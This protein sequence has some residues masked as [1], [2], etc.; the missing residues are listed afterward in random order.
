M[1]KKKLFPAM[2]IFYVLLL[3]LLIG[4]IIRKFTFT[5]KQ[6][7]SPAV[8]LSLE[9][10]EKQEKNLVD[11]IYEWMELNSDGSKS[12]IADGMPTVNYT[13]PTNE[14]QSGILDKM[15]EPKKW[16]QKCVDWTL[17]IYF[18]EVETYFSSIIPQLDSYQ[19]QVTT[20]AS[21]SDNETKTNSKD[22]ETTRER[23][24]IQSEAGT[25]YLNIP[26]EEMIPSKTIDPIPELNVAPN[27]EVL[28]KDNRITDSSPVKI[29][30]RKPRILIYH[31]HTSES[32]FD[33]KNHMD[34]TWH[35]IL[36]HLGKIVDVGE[37]LS[38]RL[39]E[40]GIEVYHDKSSYD[41]K[42][43][44]LAYVNSREG[45]SKKLNETWFD[46]IIDIHRD[47]TDLP[48]EN[49]LVNINGKPAAKVL[50][51]L[52]KGK[53]I[54][55]EGHNWETNYL[56]C[57]ALAKKTDAKYP[58]LLRRIVIKDFKRYNQDLHPQAIL[59]EIG[60]QKNTTAEAIYSA[61]L[62]AEVIAELFSEQP[63]FLLD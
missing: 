31:T 2:F 62:L 50:Y 49:Y 33:D 61:Q 20:V 22:I 24:V 7:V 51:L 41:G 48:R 58:D 59:F 14:P 40:L 13:K 32:Y 46:M 9:V 25:I 53:V 11:Q 43:F 26:K 29:N 57:S 19:K 6:I 42:K 47:G 1:L 5:P 35:A 55:D 39:Q 45:V 16:M 15:I 18:G 37:A 17:D 63:V 23:R 27:E 38:N 54:S 3:S 52:T 4:L 60:Y 12:I 10:S 8:S 36:P 44:H 28:I 34:E 56:I 30:Q 21:V